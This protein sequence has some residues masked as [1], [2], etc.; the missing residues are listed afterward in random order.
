MGCEGLKAFGIDIEKGKGH[1]EPE[2]EDVCTLYL[3]LH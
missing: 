2:G 1:W 3:Y